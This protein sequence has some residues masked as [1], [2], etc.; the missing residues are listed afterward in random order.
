M[1]EVGSTQGP[2]CPLLNALPCSFFPPSLFGNDFISSIINH[3]AAIVAELN[4][5]RLLWDQPQGRR[6]VS[7]KYIREKA[8]RESRQA[9]VGGDGLAAHGC[10]PFPI[11]S[12]SDIQDTETGKV[13]HATSP[14]THPTGERQ[15]SACVA[16]VS[17]EK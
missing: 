9:G 13:Y 10:R 8:D 12:E 17:A 11:S 7:R 3:L 15:E 14:F 2:C 6:Q 4:P 5:L 16:I 1:G